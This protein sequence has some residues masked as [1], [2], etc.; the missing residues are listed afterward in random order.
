[1]KFS[2]EIKD[3]IEVDFHAEKT[4]IVGDDYELTWSEFKSRVNMLSSELLKNNIHQLNKPVIIY[5]HKSA[6]MI[7]AMYACIKANIGYVPV[8]IIYPAER[9]KKII[10]Q[11]GSKLI[12]NTTDQKLGFANVH[13]VLYRSSSFKETLPKINVDESYTAADDKLVYTIFTSGS[14]GEPKGVQITTEAVQSFVRWMCSDFG[15]SS[16]D[17]F[18]NTAILSFDLSVFELMTFGAIGGTIVLTSRAIASE[19]KKFIEHI[20]QHKGTVL[21]ATPSFVLPYCRLN[22]QKELESLSCFLFCGEILPNSTAKNLLE[23]F[24]NARVINTYGP[25]EATVA[26]TIVEI[27]K[28]IVSKYDSLPVGV[29]KPESKLLIEE[30]EIVI[31]GPNVSVGYLNNPE[32]NASKFVMRDGLR[33][34]KTGDS[35]YLEN[36][37]LFFNGRNDDLVKLHG[38]RIEL[39]EITNALHAIQ[40]VI[41][42]ATIGLKRDG[43]VK[44]IVS[45]VNAEN[46]VSDST[47]LKNEL[48]KTLPH[49]MI[50][51]DIRFVKEIPLNANG[52]ADKKLLTEIY[53]SAR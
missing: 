28:E 12:L 22:G 24:K 35:G 51:A 2:F 40:G 1:M 48:A 3:F 26:T 53:L 8:D 47:M 50:P 13:E 29:S 49:Y 11:S 18:V 44:K 36:G 25:T 17:V 52:K 20:A 31:A 38:Y 14:T 45:L 23:N 34:F 5:G 32:L 15:F 10:F 42:A 19:P 6:G 9:I 33:A 7:V 21:I 16:N 41:Q 37:M 30:G 39:N 27:T 46:A 4:A 43:V